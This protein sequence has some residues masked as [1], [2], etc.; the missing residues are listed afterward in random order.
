MQHML[1]F[2]ARPV[3]MV[4]TAGKGMARRGVLVYRWEA[5]R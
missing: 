1:C 4:G 2:T 3:G 5:E